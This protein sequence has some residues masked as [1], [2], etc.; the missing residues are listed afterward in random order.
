MKE[1]NKPLKKEK[2]KQKQNY[3]ANESISPIKELSL[4]SVS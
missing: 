1:G 4:D 3:A 2:K